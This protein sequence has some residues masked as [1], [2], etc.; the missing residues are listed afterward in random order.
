MAATSGQHSASR[1]AALVRRLC[2]GLLCR[3]PSNSNC[4]PRHFGGGNVRKVSAGRDLRVGWAEGGWP[5]REVEAAAVSTEVNRTG[6]LTVDGRQL[7]IGSI[8][9]LGFFLRFLL[10][11]PPLVSVGQLDGDGGGL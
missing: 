9:T 8:Q 4:S 2:L 7:Q 6:N 5:G 1:L 10:R 11:V 3:P